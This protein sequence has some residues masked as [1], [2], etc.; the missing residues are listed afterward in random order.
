MNQSYYFITPK[1]IVSKIHNLS[2]SYFSHPINGHTNTD[3]VCGGLNEI[4]HVKCL[5]FI[6][7]ISCTH[8]MT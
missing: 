8:L 5:V 4:I 6:K 7:H 2:E 1:T 3:K